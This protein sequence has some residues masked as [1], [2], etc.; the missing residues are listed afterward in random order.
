MPAVGGMPNTPEE[1]VEPA[2]PEAALVISGQNS[3][4]QVSDLTEGTGNASVTVNDTQEQQ[5]W[6]GFGGTFNE[7]GWEA[8]SSLSE[9]DR[10]KVL[11]LLFDKSDGIG[12]RWGRIPI[13]SSDY[14]S[15]RYSLDDTKMSNDYDMAD[16][17]LDRDREKLI[18]YIKAALE[19]NPDIKFW[20]SPWSPPPWMKDNNAYD[21]GNMKSDDTTLA[22]HALYLARFVEDY[23]K[24][25]INVFA[26]HP[27]NEPGYAQDYPSCGW[28]GTQM[29][30]Y[31]GDI[32]GPLFEMRGLDAEIWMGTL[33]NP[34]VDNG[35]GSTALGDA[36]AKP[37]IKGAGLQWGM[38]QHLGEFT[39]KGIPIWQ[40]EHQCGN[41]P[42]E[43]GYNSQKAPNDHA[44][45]EQGWGWLKTWI[46]G[47]VNAYMA[48]NMV[49]DTVGRSLDTVRPWN[50]NALIAIDTQAKKYILTPTYYLFRHFSQ[51]VDEG[52]VRVGVSGGDALAFKNPDGTLVAVLHSSGGGQTTIAIGGKSYSF[53]IPAQGWA[54]VNVAP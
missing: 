5:K 50:Q 46:G 45:A 2:V 15:S 27:Q 32:L 1:P 4:W 12:F 25:G 34:D 38:S 8:M 26:V 9:D 14:A 16:F 35:I 21:R 11:Q 13:G 3:Y 10:T 47:G 28:S 36:Q 17:S 22:A 18:P 49:L 39:N 37:Y 43:G 48:W 40:T 44:Y 24:E 6:D 54:T 30:H 29:A 20:G 52:A 42:W 41:N 31:I 7:K 23:R 53:N 51:Y 33:S 19:V